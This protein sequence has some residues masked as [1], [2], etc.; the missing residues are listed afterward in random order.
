MAQNAVGRLFRQSTTSSVC[1]SMLRP[2]QV[3]CFGSKSAIPTFTSTPSAELNEA[4]D[5]FRQELFIPLGLP[6]RQRK[7]VF[8]PKYAQALE[9]DPITVKISENEEF[10]LTPK[11]RHELPSKKD[12]MEVLHMMVATKNFSN[13]FPFLSGLRMSNYILNN[14]RW[15]YIIR[16]AGQADKLGAVIECA[17]QYSRTGLSLSN[18]NVARRL[19]FELHQMAQRADFKGEGVVKAL[20]LAE[21]AASLM[22]SPEHSIRDDSTQDPKQQPFVIGTLLELSAACALEKQSP[23]DKVIHYAQRLHAAWD[24]GKFKDEYTS[25]SEK[26]AR[27]EE[28][29]AVVHGII[30]ANRIPKPT[31]SLGTLKSRVGPIETV[32]AKQLKGVKNKQVLTDKV[33]QR[34]IKE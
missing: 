21:K 11:N 4:L 13:L 10:T 32:L 30:L 28:N 25:P 34:F 18:M 7:S 23:D 29:L 5:R 15:E 24:L 26:Q 17:R 22:D 16:K 12:A 1:Q 33:A 14:D 6:K 2:S 27:V 20:D 19:F 8:K 9:H 31:S 3:R